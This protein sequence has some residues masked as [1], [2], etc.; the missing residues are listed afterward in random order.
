MIITGL[1][2]ASLHVEFKI[3]GVHAHHATQIASLAMILQSI[4]VFHVM[5]RLLNFSQKILFVRRLVEMV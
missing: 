1:S 5:K 2:R 4:V 3:M